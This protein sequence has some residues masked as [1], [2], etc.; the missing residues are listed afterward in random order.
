[1]RVP[2]ASVRGPR[3]DFGVDHRDK[4]SQRRGGGVKALGFV[5]D[6]GG[7]VHVQRGRGRGGAARKGGRPGSFGAEERG[8]PFTE[9]ERVEVGHTEHGHVEEGMGVVEVVQVVAHV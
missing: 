2:G 4:D 1:M 6:L 9:V 7:L 5:R 8:V 3:V